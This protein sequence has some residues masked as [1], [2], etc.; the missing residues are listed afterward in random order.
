MFKKDEKTKRDQT[1]ISIDPVKF[2]ESSADKNPIDQD[3]NTRLGQNI[4]IEGSIRGEENIIVNGSMK[5]DIELEKHDFD[6]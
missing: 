4:Y 2:S 3:E 6:S 1:A 5:G